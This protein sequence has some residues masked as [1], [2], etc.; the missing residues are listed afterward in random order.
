M[1]DRE[2]ESRDRRLLLLIVLAT[3][4]LA[5]VVVFTRITEPPA[6]RPRM[7]DEPAWG[8]A[9]HESTLVRPPAWWLTEP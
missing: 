3:V 4:V 8:T 2:D 6:Q 7:A 1:G 5:L 9:T